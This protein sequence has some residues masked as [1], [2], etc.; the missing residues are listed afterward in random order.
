MQLLLSTFSSDILN[1]LIGLKL[2]KLVKSQENSLN[3]VT[4]T[5]FKSVKFVSEIFLKVLLLKIFTFT[6]AYKIKGKSDR[7]NQNDKTIEMER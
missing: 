3:I 7:V 4:L 6:N 5:R 1:E 2:P